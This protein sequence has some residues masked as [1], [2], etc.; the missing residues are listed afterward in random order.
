VREYIVE[1]ASAINSVLLTLAAGAGFDV[2]FGL[3]ARI[4]AFLMS[5]LAGALDLLETRPPTRPN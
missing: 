1:C 4:V 5:D 2:V 3:D